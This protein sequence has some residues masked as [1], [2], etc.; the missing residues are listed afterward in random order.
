VPE[1]AEQ[2]TRFAQ[3][4]AILERGVAQ[5]A[6]PGAAFAVTSHGKLMANAGVGSFTYDEGSPRV[7]AETIFDL[8]SLAKVIATTTMA[9]ILFERGRLD[10]NSPVASIV[11]E[12]AES[13]HAKARVTIRMLL[14]HSSGVPAH[15][16]LYQQAR[17][18]DEIVR[19]ALRVPLEAEPGAR[20]V[21]SD[22]GFIVLG[23]ALERIA[24]EPLD[25]FCAREIFQPLVMSQ[26]C[27]TP[28]AGWKSE[29]PPTVDDR[30]YRL[31]VVQGEVF[32]QNGHVMGGV[33][34]HVGLFGPADD[35][36]HFAHCML[37]GGAPILHPETIE[38]FTKRESLPA[39]TS[40]ALAWDTPSAPSQS[41]KYFSPESFGHLGYTGTSLWCDPERELSV[42]LLTNRTWPDANS[43][44]IRE[45]RP[46]FHDAIIEALERE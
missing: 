39:G 43:Q 6:F 25:R 2:Q 34:G 38:L 30:D 23:E 14:A 19:A 45:I 37:S 12:F 15:V 28:P 20:A 33:S 11:P 17:N 32:D 40:R 13:D 7:H 35:V 41:G 16:K 42:T 27:F 9:M 4:F 24:G 46:A 10:L 21:Y 44:A 22:I 18:R 29:I 3:A 26:T 36:A 8:A 31:R 1:Y 5:H